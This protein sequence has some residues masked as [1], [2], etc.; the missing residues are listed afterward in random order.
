MTKKLYIIFFLIYLRLST[1]YSQEDFHLEYFNISDG[2]SQNS[3]NCLLQD[4]QGFLWIGTQD[5]LNR[6]DGYNFKIFRHNPL[7]SNSIS[8]NLINHICLAPDSTIWLA[9]SNGLNCYI[10]KLNQFKTYY[11][12]GTKSSINTSMLYHV[13]IDSE[14]NVWTKNIENLI[15]FDRK[16]QKFYSYNLDGNDFNPASA[17]NNF[18]IIEDEYQHLWIGTKDGLLY[19]D[20]NIEQFIPYS[21]RD[22]N[23]K[24]ISHNE[25][26]TIFIHSA[27]AFIVGTSHGLNIFN[28][29][30]KE[31][32]QFFIEPKASKANIINTINRFQKNKLLLGTNLGLYIFDE[33]KQIVHFKTP[34]ATLNK[35][36]IFDIIFDKS[37]IIW[38]G[39]WNG[40]YKLNINPKKFKHHKIKPKHQEIENYD[41]SALYATNRKIYIGTWENGLTLYDRKKKSTITMHTQNK[42][43]GDNHIYSIYKDKKTQL[44]IG[45]LNGLY[46]YDSLKQSFL[47]FKQKFGFDNKYLCYNNRI[48][49]IIEGY[50]STIWIGAFNGL[51]S[52]DG[53]KIKRFK[54]NPNLPNT[55]SS[56]QINC[57]ITDQDGYIWI[58]TNNGL[59]RYDPLKNEFKI[60]K[61][62]QKIS[63][64]LSHNTV[65]SLYEDKKG[66][67]WVGT[68]SGLN[69]YDKTTQ[70]FQ[71][72]TQHNGLA[73]DFIYSILSDKNNHIWVSTNRGL[74]R[75]DPE[76]NRIT[77][78]GPDD[79]LQGYEFNIGVSSKTP[80]GE[81]FFGGLNGFNSFFPD[82]IQKNRHIPQLAFT[83]IE[84]IDKT[85]INRKPINHLKK[86]TINNDVYTFTIE[87]TALEYTRPE[88]NHYQYMLKGYNNKWIPTGTKNYISF[89]EIPPGVY[90]LKIKGSNSDLIW[91]EDPISLEIEIKPGWY[92]HPLHLFFM[93]FC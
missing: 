63:S 9:T 87:F 35:A 20:K 15:K 44:W 11:P 70:R 93:P 51:Y 18:K 84:R 36:K 5:G 91:N 73:N 41:I 75:L 43:I 45:T 92:N 30:N 40:I 90:V 8:S 16:K 17:N 32:N 24:S 21:H 38:L 48:N 52:F 78:F 80:A 83:E 12:P 25:V 10:P 39:T 29:Q 77:N 68:V 27:G 31:F 57:L 62:V 88:K 4:Y 85:G 89:S 14:G 64:S 69:K 59:N 19:F 67:I 37:N 49:S 47:S 13:F 61:H 34:D 28:P 72:Y 60:F 65:L 22:G 7:D 1:G 71:Y 74:S 26:R 53:K 81:L 3:V 42:K 6:Y 86:I 23:P 79:G 82:S 76:N 2:L 66:F 33:K 58:G 54:N 56:N 46:L 50:D 55:L